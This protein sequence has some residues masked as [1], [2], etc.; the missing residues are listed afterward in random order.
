MRLTNYVLDLWAPK[1]SDEL[2][3]TR[4]SRCGLVL[5]A[6]GLGSRFGSDVPK[7]FL[8]L[9]GKPVYIHSL[10]A[11]RRFV[12][13]AVVVVPARM[14]L[15]VH[16]QLNSCDLPFVLHVVE[17]GER[18][19]DSVQ[20]GLGYLGRQIKSVLIHDAARPFV[21]ED[22]IKR[23]LEGTVHFGACIPVLPVGETVKLV[24]SEFVV[25]T[26]DREQLRLSQTPQGFERE[27][28]EE[29]FSEASQQELEGTDEASLVEQFGYKVRVIDGD[30]ANMKIT[31]QSDLG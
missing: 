15:E 3:V 25:K 26:L 12:G 6:A 13:E 27:L 7:Q 28:L 17:G 5:A 22:L 31:W 16:R 29:S 1:E 21:S 30:R 2:S 8:D 14:K 18:R 20:A 4:T 11:F 23:V 9:H 24:E 19:Q 10:E